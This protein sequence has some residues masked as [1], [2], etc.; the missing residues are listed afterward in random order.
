MMAAQKNNGAGFTGENLVFIVGSPRS[1][2][3]W[4]QRM[5]AS[6]PQVK[7][8]QESRLFQYLGP[9]LRLWQED[10][11]AAKV[12]GH[13]GAGL[14]CYL[15]EA[16]FFA[17]QR[18]QLD[19]ILTHM[20]KE[21]QP[22]QIFLEKTPSHALF[23]PEIRQWLP[24]A[25]IIHLV[26]DPRDVVASLLAAGKSW[27]N[28]WAPRKVKR[29]VRIW[30]EHVGAAQTEGKRLPPGQFLEIHYEDLFADPARWLRA[31]AD[32]LHLAWPEEELQA[33]V[34][35]NSAGELRQGKGTQIPIRGVLGQQ[36]DSV[37]Q[38]PRG[39]VRKAQPGTWKQ[40]LSLLERWKIWYHL[41]R[42]KSVGQRP[43]KK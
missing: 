6:H 38:E 33:A 36:P 28:Y 43:V 4:L 34:A 42:F 31:A 21:V 26:R 32:F 1:G 23:I 27:G 15:N 29:A 14:V 35:A 30:R 9:Q 12:S 11:N 39:F 8:G 13:R 25:K 10:M 40:D 24:A 18:T 41:R 3:T 19:A 37:V 17:I 16:E 22:G 7:T 5:L 20:L 2:T